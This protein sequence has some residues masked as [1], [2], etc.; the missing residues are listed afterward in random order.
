H[1]AR[2]LGVVRQRRPR[3]LDRLRG[4]PIARVYA[5]PQPHDTHV[6]VDISQLA[7][8]LRSGGHVRH[9]QAD[10]V[11]PAVDRGDAWHGVPPR[12]SVAR[13]DTGPYTSTLASGPPCPS[14]TGAERCTPP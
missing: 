9:Q 13:Y 4:Q 2:R 14:S 3:T 8:T 7:P 12:L 5:L 10:R 11:R 6:P 1:S